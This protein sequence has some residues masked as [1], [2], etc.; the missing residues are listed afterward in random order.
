[1]KRAVHT[2]SRVDATLLGVVLNRV[3]P[4][5]SSEYGYTYYRSENEA[6]TH[7][8][9]NGGGRGGRRDARRERRGAEVDAPVG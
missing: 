1:V 5:R 4:R 3:P 6:P 8:R 9:R 2:L 7:S